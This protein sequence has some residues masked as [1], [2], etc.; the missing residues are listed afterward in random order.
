MRAAHTAMLGFAAL[1][2]VACGD[3]RRGEVIVNWTFAGQDCRQAGVHTIRFEIPGEVL[4]PNEYPCVNADNSVNTGAHLG[5][6]FFNTY[7]LT[8]TGFDVDDTAT[9]RGSQTFTVNGDIVLNLDLQ[10]LPSTVATADVSWDALNTAT[11]G[12]AFGANG[13]MTCA[14]AQVDV[15]RIF[16]D[17]NADGTGGISA[18]DVACDTSGVEGALVS[19]LTGGTTHSFAISGIRHTPSGDVLVYQTTHPPSAAFQNGV[20]T[21][22]DVN[23]DS[24]GSGIGSAT[25]NWG[26]GCSGTVTYTLTPPTGTAMP[27][28]SGASCATPVPLNGVT[29]GLWRVDATSSTLSAHAFFGVP[30]QSTAAWTIN[31]G[32]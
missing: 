21:N 7:T 4:T 18:G 31:F 23:A 25:L 8:V 26:T 22:V 3:P 12:F 28:V 11:G 14:E 30:N 32:P 5:F 2:L 19:N 20:T 6:Y 9:Y 17:P 24:N 1:A 13:A 27:T 29:A 10:Q 16:V 15:V